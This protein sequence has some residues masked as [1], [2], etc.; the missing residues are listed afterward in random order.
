VDSFSEGRKEGR[1]RVLWIYDGFYDFQVQLHL[2]RNVCKFLSK[3]CLRLRSLQHFESF[4][5]E[6]FEEACACL[7]QWPKVP[8]KSALMLLSSSEISLA[9]SI[10]TQ[11]RVKRG[12][13]LIMFDAEKVSEA[14]SSRCVND[15]AGKAKRRKINS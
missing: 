1:C 5:G 4:G 6:S 15:A 13:M 7:L 2:S 3:I 12:F 14:Q 8:L 10:N 9:T 11:S